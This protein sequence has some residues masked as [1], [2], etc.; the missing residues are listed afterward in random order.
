MSNKRI[1]PIKTI[2]LIF[3]ARSTLC[4]ANISSSTYFEIA[5]CMR[6]DILDIVTFY[7]DGSEFNFET[8][9]AE[10]DSYFSSFMLTVATSMNYNTEL[11]S[12]IAEFITCWPCA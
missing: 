9:F 1:R 12:R 10:Q 2:V 5:S 3:T 7:C 6:V 11:F 4:M 8:S